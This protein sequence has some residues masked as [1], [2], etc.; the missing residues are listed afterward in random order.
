MMGWLV[1]AVAI[2]AVAAVLGWSLKGGGNGGYS[3]A[4]QSDVTR[5][6]MDM[7]LNQRHEARV[8]MRRR[9]LPPY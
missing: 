6:Q 5:A 9:W 3:A 8:R 7:R 2:I 1:I 4:D